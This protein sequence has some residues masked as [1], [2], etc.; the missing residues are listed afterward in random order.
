MSDRLSDAVRRGIQLANGEAQRF[1]HY[2]MDRVHLLVG[3]LCVDTGQQCFASAVLHHLIGDTAPLVADAR[4]AC[5]ALMDTK[6][7]SAYRPGMCWFGPLPKSEGWH[8]VIADA[9][10]ESRTVNSE[11]V[12]THHLLLALTGQNGGVAAQVLARHG[13]HH[14]VVEDHLWVLDQIAWPER[15]AE[16]L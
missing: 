8:Q 14:D 10:R 1:D 13:L 16:V 7:Q 5:A 12:G 6:E 15:A 9:D 11:W 4:L 2:M 3:L